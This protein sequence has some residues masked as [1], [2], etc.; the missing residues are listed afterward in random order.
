MLANGFRALLTFDKNL[1]YQQNLERYTLT[2]FVLS[3]RLN[4][5][6]VLTRL[7]AKVNLFLSGDDLPLEPVIMREG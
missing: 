6:S 4:Q 3:A 5:Y 2:V 1:Q 7:P